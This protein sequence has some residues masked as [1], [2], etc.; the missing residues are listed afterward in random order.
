MAFPT[1]R[2]LRYNLLQEAGKSIYATIPN[3]R[4]IN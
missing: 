2:A 1:G 3:A 4:T